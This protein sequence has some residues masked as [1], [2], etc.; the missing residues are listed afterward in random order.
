M[1]IL[2]RHGE[3]EA[4][5]L[6]RFADSDEISLTEAGRRQAHET[7]LRLARE[8]RPDLVLTSEFRRARETGEIIALPLGLRAETI[9][10]IHE[11]NFGS[12]KGQP[13]SYLGEAMARDTGCEPAKP[14]LW[15]PAG[16]ESLDQVQ[17]RA[18]RALE[19]IR[20]RHEG[21][22]VIVVSH[23]A[24]IQSVCAHITGDWNE[25][26]MPVN[27]GIVV[28]GYNDAGWQWPLTKKGPHN[29]GP[30]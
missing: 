2:V 15:C 30:C 1:I 4:N 24:V 11:R 7:A 29:G 23:G 25:N 28:I 16:G 3:T 10:G 5:R 17:Q 13:Y 8:F 20:T 6:G 12:L 14:W 27:C 9:A 18:M 19:G 26:Y 22:Q 21:K